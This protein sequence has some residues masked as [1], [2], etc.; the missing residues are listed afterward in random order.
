MKSW[1]EEVE[2]NCDKQPVTI[3]VGNKTD[4]SD[5]RQGNFIKI[6]GTGRVPFEL[7]GTRPYPR[8]EMLPVPYGMLLTVL[9]Q[10]GH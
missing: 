6:Q 2:I 4:L 5:Q 9:K 7:P 3:L 8:F 1:L 10:I